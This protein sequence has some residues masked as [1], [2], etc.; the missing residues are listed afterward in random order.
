MKIDSYLE[1]EGLNYFVGDTV[2]LNKY[3]SLEFECTI[4]SIGD[5]SNPEIFVIPKDGNLSDLVF[6]KLDQIEKIRKA[7]I[8]ETKEFICTLKRDDLVEIELNN[9][10]KKSIYFRCFQM[11]L[12]EGIDQ[13][14]HLPTK[15]PFCLIKSVRLLTDV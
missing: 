7:N 12:F 6:L 14:T 10:L 2:I 11:D 9:N 8:D 4:E 13:Y 3:G 15:I 1:H 5:K